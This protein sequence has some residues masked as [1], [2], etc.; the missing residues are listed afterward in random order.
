MTNQCG[1]CAR[2]LPIEDG[3][4]MDGAR[5]F[6]YCTA[7][8]HGTLPSFPRSPYL[9]R[10]AENFCAYEEAEAYREDAVLRRG[11]GVWP[12]R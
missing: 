4:H 10:L 8:R 12:P 9:D 5:R 7:E 3:I 6:M 11:G 1:G 2:G